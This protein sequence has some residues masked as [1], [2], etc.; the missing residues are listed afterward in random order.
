MGIDL[1]QGLFGAAVASSAAILAVGLLGKPMRIAFGARAAYWL[2]LL[3]P[4][5]VVATLLPAPS[6]I[7][8]TSAHSVVRHLGSALANIVVTPTIF[9]PSSILVNV[10]LA[11]WGTGTCASIALVLC[12]QQS[13]ARSLGPI[14]RDSLDRRRSATIIAPMLVGAWRAEVVL[15][16]DFE[17][18]YSEAERALI[19]AHE[20]AH[21]LRCDVSAN[22]VAAGSLCLLW[23]NP[24]MYWAV[25]R[26]RLDQE[27]ACDAVVLASPGTARRSYADALL[28][29]Q[30]AIQSA[31]RLPIGCQWQSNHPL[32]ERIAML[33]HTTPG[34]RR[35][36]GGIA[37]ALALTVSGSYAAWAA[38][39]RTQDAS[40]PILVDLRLTTTRPRTDG[41]RAV[42]INDDSTQYLVNSGGAAPNLH[43]RALDFM[44]KASVAYGSANSS[45][46]ADQT[47]PGIPHLADGQILLQCEFQHDGKVTAK[48]SIVVLDGQKASVELGDF[49][50]VHYRLE[51]TAYSSAEGIKA[52]VKR[53][54]AAMAASK[55]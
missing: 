15:P 28:R 29:T 30:L 17:S 14:Y 38:Q 9:H 34:L 2:W 41:S 18:R 43:L 47:A 19:L 49:Q 3:V 13:F 36:F 32:K 10:A 44:C 35:R 7:L 16:A 48:P 4:A 52:A 5:M 6:R 51:V 24:L 22:A 40:T 37:L 27:L 1:L 8:Q 33:K 11:I 45:V 53:G 26:L 39:S 50:R 46:P 55:H 54:A 23:F 21:L 25:G 20:T 42:D 31:W 12:R